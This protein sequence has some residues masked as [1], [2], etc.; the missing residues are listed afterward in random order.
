MNRS[1]YSSSI[2]SF[3]ATSLN[4][5]LGELTR[6]SEFSVDQTQALAWIEQIVL[7]PIL[8]SKVCQVL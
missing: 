6:V 7:K 5:M 1:Y 2:E 3:L 4:A 8:S